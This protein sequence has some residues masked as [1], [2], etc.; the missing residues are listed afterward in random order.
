MATL[1]KASGE[2]KEITPHDNVKFELEESQSLVGGYIQ[3]IRIGYGE[4]MILDEEGKL[5]DKPVNMVATLVAKSR[6]AI[7]SND[8]IVGDVILC[9]DDEI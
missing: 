9:K 7:F 4:V 1:I 2:T 6:R 3:I 5:K 8:C